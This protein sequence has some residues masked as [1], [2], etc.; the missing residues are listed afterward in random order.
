MKI[1]RI[2]NIIGHAD[3]RQAASR[4]SYEIP[5][6]AV[7][8][9]FEIGYVA[10]ARPQTMLNDL[11]RMVTE[12][13]YVEAG[14]RAQAEGF[15]AIM[16]GPVADYGMRQLRSVVSI[17]VVGAGQSSMQVAAGLGRRFAIVTVWPEI[18]RPA[19]ERQLVDYGF[20]GHCSGLY[21]V[22]QDAELPAMLETGAIP[23][24]CPLRGPACSTAWRTRAGQLGPK[25]PR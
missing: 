5:A 10:L 4:H 14:L 13:A 20:A 11:D 15:D 12:L 17:P 18:L 21:F 2:A 22:T 16:I 1:L 7:S 3:D 25:V 24:L 9:G 6:D 8:P 19:Y 23:S